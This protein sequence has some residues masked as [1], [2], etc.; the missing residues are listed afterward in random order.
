MFL[1]RRFYGEWYPGEVGAAISGL[2]AGALMSYLLYRFVRRVP[3]PR[4]VRLQFVLVHLAALLAFGVSWVGLSIAIEALFTGDPLATRTVWR[5]NALPSELPEISLLLYIIVAGIGYSVEGRA[6]TARIEADAMRAQLA[7]LRA[8]LHP[9]FLFN[10]LHAVV[11]LI[12]LDPVRAEE[13]AE[14]IAS[15]LR[16]TLEEERDEVTLDDEWTFVSRYLE[17][18]RMRFGDR[19]QV[20]ADVEGDLLDER[21]PAFALQ[22]LVENAVRHG[23]AHRAAPTEIVVTAERT[24]SQLSLTVRNPGGPRPSDGPNDGTGT[25]LLRLRERLKLLYGDAARLTC[26]TREDGS[27]EAVLVVPT[28]QAR[29]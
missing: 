23:A 6:R 25:G 13:A 26:S 22:T 15:L 9:H 12:R 16:T 19:L 8:Q 3:W 24:T 28:A 18:E 14:L 29:A 11:Q 21:V 4:P 1:E 5:L 2:S 10:A 7:A 27:H 20:T 17:V